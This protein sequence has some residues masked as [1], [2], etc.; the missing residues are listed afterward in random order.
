[1]TGLT[2]QQQLALVAW[3]TKHLENEVRKGRLNPQAAQEWVTGERFAAKFGGEVAAWVS[4]PQPATRVTSHAGLLA[5]VRK[6]LPDEIE[7]A[8]RVRPGTVTALI[9]SVKEHGGWV[10][11]DGEVIPVS[12][13]ETGDPAP[14]VEVDD[15]A[16]EVIRAA[17][18]GGEIDLPA[19]LALPG[20][21]AQ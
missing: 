16:A 5:W 15:R 2:L 10:N 19:V 7:M 12:G 21:E 13:I 8:P 1:M 20:G 9:E 3:M 14:R 4:M 17:W 18:R 6:H 11:P